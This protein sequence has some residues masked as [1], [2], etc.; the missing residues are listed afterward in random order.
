MLEKTNGTYFVELTVQQDY[1]FENYMSPQIPNKMCV[2]H[3]CPSYVK[4]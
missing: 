2:L 4:F 3:N 1:M